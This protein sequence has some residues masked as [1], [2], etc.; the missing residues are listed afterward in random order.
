MNNLNYLVINSKYRQNNQSSTDF[1]IQL[2]KPIII[3]K[4]IKL[5]FSSIPESSYQINENNQKFKIVFSDSTTKQFN[6]P[7][8]N[9][10]TTSLANII[11]TNVNYDSFNIIFDTSI[12]KFIFSSATKDFTIYSVPYSINYILGFD[13]NKNY[14]STLLVL[15]GANVLNFIEP[16]MF[17]ICINNLYNPNIITNNN[18]NI[19]YIVPVTASKDDVNYF[20][21]NVYENIIYCE[22][23]KLTNLKIK[24]ITDDGQDYQNQNLDTQYVFEF[25]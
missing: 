16:S 20:N 11:K 10:N 25:F 17:Y 19:S 6:V 15:Y 2:Y 5:I 4:Y 7:I 18:Y 24:I 8:G 21:S 22:N 3:K 13:M 23:V 14:S 9:Y 12:N 1:T